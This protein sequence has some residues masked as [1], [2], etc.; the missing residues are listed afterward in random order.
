VSARLP[1]RNLIGRPKKRQEKRAEW[2]FS[3]SAHS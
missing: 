1:A 3:H 2:L